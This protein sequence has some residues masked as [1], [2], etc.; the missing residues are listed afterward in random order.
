M[1][2]MPAS[3]GPPVI[4]TAKQGYE[5]PSPVISDSRRQMTLDLDG[6]LTTTHRSLR[7]CVAQGVYKRGLK[8]VAA[9][10]DLSP[11]N[12]SVALSDD[13]HRKFSVD[14][15]EAYVRA[16]G[17]KTPVYYLV[18]KYLG[19]EAAARDQ[20]LGQVAEMLQNLP[21]L[22]AAAGLSQAG[23]RR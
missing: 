23:K 8:S 7:D 18:A 3:S 20:A 4:T 9:D 17:D 11:G 12:L 13:P 10:L 14:D 6:S 15:L 22:V 21:A 2:S 1:L 5:M 16:T 19:D